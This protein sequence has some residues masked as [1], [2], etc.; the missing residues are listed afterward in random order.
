M[1]SK[2]SKTGQDVVMPSEDTQYK[3]GDSRINRKG[4]PKKGDTWA[5]ILEEVS[6]REEVIVDKK[7]GRKIT[8]KEAVAIR[9][10]QEA[11]KGNT[12]MFN[13]I[14]NRM[15]GYPKHRVEQYNL[16]YNMDI[17][18]SDDEERQFKENIDSLYPEDIP[19]DDKPEGEV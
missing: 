11:A 3:P 17:E 18:L 19:I 15:S 10:F 5:D 16:T 8:Y 7:T 12:L 4:R 9:A 1:Q 6:E 14:M 2:S 13:A